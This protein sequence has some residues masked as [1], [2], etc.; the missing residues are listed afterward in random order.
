MGNAQSAFG[1][2]TIS[3]PD[4]QKHQDLELVTTFSTTTLAI[5]IGS[6]TQLSVRFSIL[7]IDIILRLM[8][9][10][11]GQTLIKKYKGAVAD[12]NK[13]REA[14]RGISANM[15]PKLVAKWERL[16]KIWDSDG[17]PKSTENPFKTVD[18]S[19]Y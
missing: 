3:S 19:E 6:N 12:R 2:H 8:D 7:S 5:G 9:I 11:T 10:L 15:T 1:D 17:F 18:T 4:Q 16:C 14:H 13:Q